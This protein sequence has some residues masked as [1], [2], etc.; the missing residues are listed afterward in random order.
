MPFGRVPHQML[1]CFRES[2]SAPRKQPQGRLID[3]E[4]SIR[5]SH[6]KNVEMHDD[7]QTDTVTNAE[8]MG[9]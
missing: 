7:V 3:M 1:T 4:L 9:H 8:S 6:A 5:P 2:A